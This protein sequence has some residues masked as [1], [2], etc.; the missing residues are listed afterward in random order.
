MDYE[1][2]L[3]NQFQIEEHLEECLQ[4]SDDVCSCEEI[5]MARIEDEAENR[6]EFERGN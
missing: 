3:N 2:W 5:V 6:M 1:S 4:A